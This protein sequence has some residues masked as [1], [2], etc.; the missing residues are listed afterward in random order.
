MKETAQRSVKEFMNNNA[1]S[2]TLI[3][4]CEGKITRA[5]GD[6]NAALYARYNYILAMATGQNLEKLFDVVDQ[7]TSGDEGQEQGGLTGKT[8]S[9]GDVKT[10]P[11]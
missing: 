8:T 4:H 2:G 7:E 11:S 9:E 10:Y 5:I 1:D 6:K 3:K